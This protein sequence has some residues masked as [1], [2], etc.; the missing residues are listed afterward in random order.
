[1]NKT[2]KYRWESGKLYKYNE[3]ANAY[4]FVC[5]GNGKSEKQT[6]RDFERRENLQLDEY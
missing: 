5:N 6:I 4:I 1:M 3:S 2:N